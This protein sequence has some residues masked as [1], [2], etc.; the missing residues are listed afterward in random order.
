M[1][2]IEVEKLIDSAG[3]KIGLKDDLIQKITQP[4]RSIEINL[5]IKNDQRRFN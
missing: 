5:S 2:Y 4:E 3:K 1:S